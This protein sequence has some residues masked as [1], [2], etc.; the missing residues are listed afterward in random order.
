MPSGLVAL[1]DD[2]SVIAKMA[3]S[4]LDDVDYSAGKALQGLL[5]YLEA[6]SITPVLARV[7]TS[8]LATLQKYGI[9]KRIGTDHIFGNLIDAYNAFEARAQ[10]KA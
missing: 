9:D 6:R 4:S 8:L 2:I 3:A 5:D 1:L 7:D 10:P